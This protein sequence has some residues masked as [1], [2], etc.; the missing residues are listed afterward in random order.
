MCNYLCVDAVVDIVKAVKC[1]K[2]HHQVRWALESLL[3]S[4]HW[5]CVYEV[6]ITSSHEEYQQFCLQY[7]LLSSLYLSVCSGQSIWSCWNH[8]IKSSYWNSFKTCRLC[9]WSRTICQPL[10]GHWGSHRKAPWSPSISW[11]T[12]PAGRSCCRQFQQQTQHCSLHRK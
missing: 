10:Q 9:L 8:I 5:I 4:Q 3:K 11:G 1:S 7:Y 2:A 6:F 12:S